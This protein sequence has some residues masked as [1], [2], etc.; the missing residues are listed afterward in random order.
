MPASLTASRT[1][2]GGPALRSLGK[3]QWL[4]CGSDNGGQRAAVI[5]SLIGTAMLN[6]VD[7]QAWLADVDDASKYY[8]QPEIIDAH[9]CV[10]VRCNCI[11]SSRETYLTSARRGP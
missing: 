3:T 11:R 10:A 9:H 7:P 1:W 2:V 5:Y 8:H 6:G 4:F